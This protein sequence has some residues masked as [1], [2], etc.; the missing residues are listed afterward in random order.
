MKIFEDNQSTIVITKNQQFNGWEKHTDIELHYIREQVIAKTLNLKYCKSKD[1][2]AD[3]L[4]KK[5]LGKIQFKKLK[6]SGVFDISNCKWGGMLKLH[7][8]EKYFRKELSRHLRTSIYLPF[9][10]HAI[11]QENCRHDLENSG[12]LNE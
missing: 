11:K 6:M 4:K 7:T 3:I 1:I 5:G 8:L 9:L 12:T 10:E 2:I